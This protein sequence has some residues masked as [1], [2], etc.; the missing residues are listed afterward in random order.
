MS[1]LR[2]AAQKQ[3]SVTDIVA[4]V[5]KGQIILIDVREADEVKASGKARTALHIPLGILAVKADPAAPD[6]PKALT[7]NLPIAVYCA[8]GGRSGMAA[9]VLKKLGYPQ[10]INLG[11]LGD[12]VSAGGQIERV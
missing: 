7:H 4:A 12:W 8:A 10:V 2:P 1:I 9:Q 11:G 5:A 3:P 6:C